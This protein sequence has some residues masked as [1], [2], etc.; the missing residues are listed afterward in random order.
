MKFLNKSDMAVYSKGRRA[1]KGKS[2]KGK[3]ITCFLILI[4]IAAIVYLIVSNYCFGLD[5]ELSDTSANVTENQIDENNVDENVIE[6][7]SEEILD[8]VSFIPAKMSGFDV[9]GQLVIDKIGLKKN[10]LSEYSGA[11]LDVSVTKFYG[12]SINEPGNFC[13]CGHNNRYM[14]KK[15]STLKAGD[16]FYI[17]NRATKSKVTYQVYKMY[18]CGPKDLSCLEQN[19]DGKKEVTLITC[20]PGAARRVICKAREA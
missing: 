3:A 6:Q 7:S 18:T 13:A 19:N 15:L 1:Q 20:T 17:I 10:I 12:P 16:T 4:I 14:L 11:A 2:N 9:L 8:D 5:S